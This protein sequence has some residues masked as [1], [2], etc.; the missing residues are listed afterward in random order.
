[1]SGS[2]TLY[3]VYGVSLAIHLLVGG[4]LSTI[5]PERELEAVAIQLANIEEPKEEE[6]EP[7]PEP[8]PVEAPKP[9]P[10]RAAPQPQA[11]VPTAAP[12]PDFGFA[13][14]SGGGPGGIAVAA[15]K[16]VQTV[17]QAA[18]KVLSSAA[19]VAPEGGCDEAE[20]KPKKLSGPQPAY[21]EEANLARIEGKVR[22][23][24]VIAADGSVESARVVEGIG[25]GLDEAAV[26]SL[27]E[28]KFSPATR[29]G[30]AV[31]TTITV[32]VRFT[33]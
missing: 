19:S 22:V 10:K 23:E 8:P 14:S 30:K 26:A 1:M 33:L 28:T 20:V 5:E 2:R 24:I 21:T 29:C 11:A 3:T 7:E 18:K 4:G 9:A 16:P 15:P 31:A 6:K 32:G 25:H 13:L 27:R 17:K 12:A